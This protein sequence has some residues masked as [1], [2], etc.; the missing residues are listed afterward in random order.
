MGP[1]VRGNLGWGLRPPVRTQTGRG[2]QRGTGHILE[3]SE[4]ERM[5]HTHS[6]IMTLWWGSSK[7]G[8]RR[9]PEI[10]RSQ[11]TPTPGRTVFMGSMK[12]RR[13]SGETTKFDM[14]DALFPE[15]ELALAP[16]A[17]VAPLRSSPSAATANARP[18]D[19]GAFKAMHG[20]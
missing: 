17:Q 18:W 4:G 1:I 6:I 8:E 10:L 9:S 16:R 7:E 11:N 5:A 15:Y 14:R 3:R 19:T 2:R 13:S 20:D 12:T